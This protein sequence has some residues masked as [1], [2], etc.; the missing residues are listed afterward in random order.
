[1][2]RRC[3]S[4]GGSGVPGPVARGRRPRQQSEDP[5]PERL[6]L[7]HVRSEVQLVLRDRVGPGLGRAPHGLAAWQG[8]GRVELDQRPDLHPRPEGGLR[9][10]APAGQRRLVL[11]RRPALFPQGRGP[12]ARRRRLPR[13]RRTA[14]GLRHPVSPD[15]LR[16]LSSRPRS[17]PASRTTRTSTAR[18]RRARAITRRPRATASVA[19]RRS[20]T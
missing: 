18:P 4:L 10:L 17:R 11:R 5:H 15:D 6:L 3:A 7:D 9:P 19:A 1:M 16:R 2:R 20:A 12:A 13:H 14:E 8:A